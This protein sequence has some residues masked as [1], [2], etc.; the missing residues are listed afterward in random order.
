MNACVWKTQ[1][2][3][4]QSWRERG[5]SESEMGIDC[6]VS[7]RARSSC[8]Q[9]SRSS[10]SVTRSRVSGCAR[11]R[12]RTRTAHSGHI[13]RGPKDGQGDARQVVLCGA[14]CCRSGQRRDGQ[15]QQQSTELAA[16]GLRGAPGTCRCGGGAGRP[17]GRG[18]GRA[19]PRRGLRFGERTRGN[20]GLVSWREAPRRKDQSRDAERR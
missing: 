16:A 11:K 12:T 14:P 19:H 2:G 7:T 4:G 17:R 13:I 5:R 6:V 20:G 9:Y 10:G 18:R 8:S 3:A 1:K 15:Q